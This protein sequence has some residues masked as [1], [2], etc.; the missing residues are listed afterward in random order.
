MTRG[1]NEEET[2]VDACILD[3]AIALRGKFFP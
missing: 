1:L 3:V 2:A